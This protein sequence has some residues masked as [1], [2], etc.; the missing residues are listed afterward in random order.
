M[1]MHSNLTTVPPDRSDPPEPATG[2]AE[3]DP[4]DGKPE[5]RAQ[6]TDRIFR[7][8]PPLGSPEYLSLLKTATA[9]EL[10]AEVLVR[11]YRQ[12]K[13][14]T[15]AEQTLV[16]LVATN[17]KYGYLDA[18]YKVARRR[19]TDDDA[20]GVD[21]LVANA[22]GEIVIRLPDSAGAGAETAWVSF[23]RQ[24]VVDA[25]R[26]LVGRHGG[27]RPRML[28]PKVDRETQEELDP[29]E[30]PNVLSAPWHGT[31]GPD[32]EEWFDAFARRTFARIPDENIRTVGLN[33]LRKEPLPV[34]AKDPS[35]TETLEHLLK[36]NSYQIYR[37][38]RTALA[39]LRAALDQQDERDI[40]VSRLKI[41]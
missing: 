28:R 36:A 24:R 41:R 10:P 20:Y 1:P 22:I 31:V 12:L 13:V 16:R 4:D 38:Q 6:R 18:L 39:I 29:L 33:F 35:N 19:I 40:D 37:W 15:A 3:P 14:G 32:L 23:C 34:S 7:Q 9:R 17:N 2:S 5:S 11:A 8:L 21:D 27:R 26:E 25:H 30:G